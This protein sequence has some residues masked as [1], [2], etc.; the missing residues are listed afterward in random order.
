LRT[1]N[2]DALAKSGTLFTQVSSQVPLTL[3]SHVSMLTSTY[4][5]SNGVQDN[6]QPL[7]PTTLTLPSI[8][9]S[10][11]YRTAAFVGS[12]VLDRRFGLNQGFDLYDSPFNLR[13]ER[14]SDPGD[15]KR[16]GE[17]VAESAMHWLESNTD[18]IPFFLFLHLYDLHQPYD[19]PS[20]SHSKSPAADYDAAL[21]YED[22][23]LGKFL[24][25][26]RQKKLLDKALVVFTSDHGE[27]LGEHGESTHGYFIYQSTL[28][29]PLIVRWPDSPHLRGE[30]A[31]G[32]RGVSRSQSAVQLAKGTSPYAPFKGEIALSSSPVASRGGMEHPSAFAARVNEP[33]GLIDIAPTILQ[34][35]GIRRP[36]DFQ[37]SG[38]LELATAKGPAPDREVVSES[39]YAKNH[40]GC[41]WL[42]SLRF[43]SFKYVLAPKPELYDLS[44][45]PREQHNLYPEQAA[46]A[47]A[48]GERLETLRTRYSPAQPAASQTLNPEVVAALN[49]LGYAAVSTAKSSASTAGADPKDRI[50]DF[51]ANRLAVSISSQGN[52]SEAGKILERLSAKYPDIPDLLISLGVSLRNQGRQQE[53]ATAFRKALSVDPTNVRGHFDLAI[54]YH[55]LQRSEEALKEL[56]LI[57][58]MAPYYSRAAELAGEIRLQRREP[59]QA[60]AVFTQMLV[61][62]PGSYAAHYHLGMLASGKGE[63]SEAER[64]FDAAARSDPRSAEAH[65]GLGVVY[66]Q[67]G[68]L[69][70]AQRMLQEA[71]RLEPKWAETHFNLGLVL[72]KLSRQD[73][74][75]REF[76]AALAVD[77]Q[78][79]PAREAL[80][81]PE[82]R[83]R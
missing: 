44:R 50:A 46:R 30:G 10:H 12:F 4:P 27:S 80:N 26:L 72:R 18:G 8:L 41:S 49:S 43:G 69:E 74:A 42:Q 79:R 28:H 47:R 60:R 36:Q 76:R 40:F 83:A 24:D 45:D 59:E 67:T 64:H 21:A 1:P 58:T 68:K 54:T 14:N 52:A 70:L 57:L 75:A 19:V 82:F 32:A 62:D 15:V 23:V 38:F 3:P 71:V 20:M 56:Q 2:I 78:F 81:S 7:G 48:L 29:V 17:E 16:L 39:L 25:F 61:S 5:F 37:G 53:A 51:E 6:G 73:E 11:G 13:R 22:R 65:N 31:E 35:L 33:V 9:K 77:P 66:L 34:F 55:E 63:W